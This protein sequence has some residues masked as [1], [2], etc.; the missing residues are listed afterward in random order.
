MKPKKLLNLLL[1]STLSIAIVACNSGTSSGSSGSNTPT[2]TPPVGPVSYNMLAAAY[3]PTAGHRMSLDDV[4][5][6]G[7][8]AYEALGPLPTIISFIGGQRSAHKQKQQFNELF[9]D[10]N[11][12]ESQLNV[13]QDEVNFLGST[14][15][16]YIEQQQQSAADLAYHAYKQDI[17]YIS[18][19]SNGAL[20]TFE[21]GTGVT[22]WSES[23]NFSS[24]LNRISDIN[25]E[26]VHSDANFVT[27]VNQI[28]SSTVPAST[29]GDP[30]KSVSTMSNSSVEEL[31][32]QM[33]S[34]FYTKTLPIFNPTGNTPGTNIIPAIESYNNQIMYIY[35]NSVASLQAAYSVSAGINLLNYKQGVA[36]PQSSEYIKSLET[37]YSL[38]YKYS[39]QS[40]QQESAAYINAQE[41]L[42]LV[43]AARINYLYKTTLQYIISDQPLPDF[44]YPDVTT[45]PQIM[46]KYPNLSYANLFADTVSTQSLGSVT[47]QKLPQVSEW[48]TILYMYDGLNQ[49]PQCVEAEYSGESLNTTNCPSVYAGYAP[50]ANNTIYDGVNLQ[51]WGY[52]P[53]L[54][55][56]QLTAAINLQDR[57]GESTGQLTWNPLTM[58]SSQTATG[59][60]CFNNNA[61]TSTYPTTA[62]YA[63]GTYAYNKENFLSGINKNW[64]IEG[65]NGV[66][67]LSSNYV[68]S[69]GRSSTGSSNIIAPNK[70]YTQMYDDYSQ[71]TWTFNIFMN[72][73][74]NGYTGTIITQAGGQAYAGGIVNP[75]GYCPVSDPMCVPVAPATSGGPLQFCFGGNLLVLGGDGAGDGSS[76][77]TITYEGPC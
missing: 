28:S 12:I 34:V 5:S 67:F 53:N 58:V 31:Y 29:T 51:L 70:L 57:C 56:S 1:L 74:I 55:S 8:G 7:K 50:A 43:Y 21:A 2:K 63:I 35:Q 16:Q 24:I 48:Y 40:S 20:Y 3:Q 76:P 30:Y 62:E 26:L 42:A 37:N 25:D 60:G 66:T 65:V 64:Y 10:I 14:F 11:Q 44:T 17:S 45:N 41:Q 27:A 52:N 23:V 68:Q 38:F 39:G 13:L 15:Y 47:A 77:S 6:I 19:P 33:Q 61:P 75:S 69:N 4:A 36:N 18:S 9:A 46:Q 73:S 71:P 32:K 54:G 22:N 59:F 49:F 72:I